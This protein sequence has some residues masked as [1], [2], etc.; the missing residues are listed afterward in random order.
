MAG[1]RVLNWDHLKVQSALTNSKENVS[2]CS[3]HEFDVAHPADSS[4]AAW[5]SASKDEKSS[6]KALVQT[7]V[8]VYRKR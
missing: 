7:H 8:G 3:A 1:G 2:A 5:Q 6:K 4:P